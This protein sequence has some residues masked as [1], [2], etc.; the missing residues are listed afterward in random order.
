MHK[1]P[2]EEEAIHTHLSLDSVSPLG[3]DLKYDHICAFDAFCFRNFLKI[4]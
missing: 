1:P 2:I 4:S 3:K